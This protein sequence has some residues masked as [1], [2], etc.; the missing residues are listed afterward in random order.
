VK[1][2]GLLLTTEL[3]LPSY[4][5]ILMLTQLMSI[6]EMDVTGNAKLKQDLHALLLGGAL[7]YVDLAHMTTTI[8]LVMMGIISLMMVVMQI[9]R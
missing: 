3:I 8:F 6:G 5:M 7:R 4:V 1:D 9:V 2:A